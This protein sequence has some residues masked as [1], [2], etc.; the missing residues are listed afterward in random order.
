MSVC[1]EILTP[2]SLF[3]FISRV[4]LLLALYPSPNSSRSPSRPLYSSLHSHA[5]TRL[6][7]SLRL[8]G[9]VS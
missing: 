6:A 4:I 5:A 3:T 1:S 9:T 7:S 8:S 2:N